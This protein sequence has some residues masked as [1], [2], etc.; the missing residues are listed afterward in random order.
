MESNGFPYP[1]LS[2]TFAEGFS[3]ILE[4]SFNSSRI[5]IRSWLFSIQNCPCSVVSVHAWSWCGGLD[6]EHSILV[7][8]SQTPQKLLKHWKFCMLNNQLLTKSPFS[9]KE[10]FIDI[11][12]LQSMMYTYMI[13]TMSSRVHTI[14]GTSNSRHIGPLGRLQN[15]LIRLASADYKDLHHDFLN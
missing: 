11:K 7:Y 15:C 10:N 12:Q 3:K 14:V 8:G 2:C 6:E 5:L 4:L 9:L 13:R 1:Y